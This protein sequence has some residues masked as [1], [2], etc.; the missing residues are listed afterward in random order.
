MWIWSSP[1]TNSLF[2]AFH[3]SSWSCCVCVYVG[4]EMRD[5][6]RKHWLGTIIKE[7]NPFSGILNSK[8]RKARWQSSSNR[9]AHNQ[10]WHLAN[11]HTQTC[12]H[13]L[14]HVYCGFDWISC[15][16]QPYTSTLTHTQKCWSWV[17]SNSPCE[18]KDCARN[19]PF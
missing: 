3:M 2:L 11:T 5:Q 16:I 1:Y 18:T 19:E 10:L 15:I 13:T 17:F 7:M 8:Y 9:T 12:M 14:S 4:W 6:F